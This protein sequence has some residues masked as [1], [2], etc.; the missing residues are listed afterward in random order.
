M[1]YWEA[2][3]GVRKRSFGPFQFESGAVL[4][5]I[6]IAYETWGKL[7]EQKDNVVLVEHALTG[8]THAASSNFDP[9]EGWWEDYVGPGKAIDTTKYFVVCCNVLGGCSGS[10][11]PSSIN[12]QTGTRY[13]LSFPISSIRDFVNSQK[14]LLDYLGIKKIVTVIGGSM[15]GM[16]ALEWAAMYPEMVESIIPICSPGRAYPQSIAY[17]KAQRKAIMND[18]D[19]RGGN[20]YGISYPRKGIETARMMGFI[21]YRSEQEFARRF[22]RNHHDKNLFD[23]LGRFEVE[24]YLEYHGSKLTT[25]YDP[26]TYLY[27]SKAMDLHDLGRG[28]KSYEQG[29]QRI[30]AK[31]LVIGVDSD[32]LFPNYQQ[33]EIVNILS[34]TNPHVY[35]QEVKSIYGHDA[36]LIEVEQISSFIKE[37]LKTIETKGKDT[38]YEFSDQSYS[39]WN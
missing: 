11:G 12:P 1:A 32:I 15:G 9:V 29:I 6:T 25:W 22:C 28:F 17:R 4:P 13:G 39:R 20:Y 31:T 36:F 8:T 21:T 33:K 14:R 7:N 3:N 18:P 2:K 27:L 10:S 26:N 38:N 23:L 34:K 24:S 30:K 5:Q 16:Q 35:Y 19:W 37:F